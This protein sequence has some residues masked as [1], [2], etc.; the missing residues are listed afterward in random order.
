M[1]EVEN[2]MIRRIGQF[3]CALLLCLAAGLLPANGAGPLIVPAALAE[4]APLLE[5]QASAKPDELVEPGDVTLSFTIANASER[6]AQNVYLSSSDGLLSEPIG[7][8]GAGESQIFTRSHSVTQA[9]LDAGE[10]TY[11]ISHDDPLDPERKVNYTVHASIRQSDK[12]PQVEFT[13]QFSNSCFEAGDTVTILYRVRNSGNV[14]VNS[15]RVEDALGDFTGR[16]ELLDVGESR[17][18]ISRVTLSEEAVSV[19]TLSYAVN[20]LDGA[21]FTQ[22]LSE[23]TLR[24]AQ[25]RISAQLSADYSPF[26]ESTAEVVVL[27]ENAGDADYMNLCITDDV[28]GGVIADEVQLPAGSEPIAISRSYP[29]RGDGSFRWRVTGM[30][31]SGSRVDFLTNSVTLPAR[32]IGVLADVQLQATVATPRIR[33]AGT[34]TVQLRIENAGDADVTDLLLSEET[35]GELRSFAIVPAGG[36]IDCAVELDVRESSQYRFHVQYTD[37]E[38]WQGGADSEAVEIAIAP[39]GVLPE[40][41]KPSFIEFTGSSIKIGG[42]ALF[43]VLMIAGCVTLV[44]LI[45]ILAVASHR[46]RVQRQLRIAE[47]KVKRKESVGKSRKN[48]KRPAKPDAKKTDKDGK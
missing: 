38:G 25:P 29:V 13:R 47:E 46:A 33:R 11:I 3:I 18:L 43:G 1:Y 48:G 12:Q 20:A 22:T 31:A 39:D 7:Q 28:Y 5:I 10:I 35:L 30:S 24:M 41:A 14:A 16:V 6:D 9:E 27:L 37:V 34:V 21:L 4:E 32:E 2:R 15:L 8:I 23:A 26:S 19:P 40:G 44:V 36:A 42:S 45:V 17:T